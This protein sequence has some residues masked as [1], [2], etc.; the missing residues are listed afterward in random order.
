M[1]TTLLESQLAT[2]EPLSPDEPGQV[3]DGEASLDAIAE[4]VVARLVAEGRL[5]A[6][7]AT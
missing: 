1:P 3:V 2:L 7:K 4:E 6:R 5:A